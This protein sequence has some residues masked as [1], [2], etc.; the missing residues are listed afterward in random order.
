MF[1]GQCGTNM[2]DDSVF[3]PECG[4]PVTPNPA[5]APT[6]IPTPINPDPV[7]NSATSKRNRYIGLGVV[8]AAVVLVVVLCV[9]LFG[10]RSY[11]SVV[12]KGMNAL[13]DADGKA[14]INL[15]P[16]DFIDYMCDEEDVTK[17]ELI[18]ELEEELDDE[19]EG[20]SAF[21]D[22]LDIDY[23]ITKTKDF[24][25]KNLR[26]LSDECED[27]YGFEVKDAKEATI[28]FT[29]KGSTLGDIMPTMKWTV[30]KVGRN[31]C[32]WEPDF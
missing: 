26:E 20:L 30:I 27:E 14:M 21:Y 11:N 2:P 6:P 22:V 17:A 28:Q 3:C 10:G 31:W 1:C 23:E 25:K 24:S 15:F 32:L 13:L 18:D 16:K 19:L 8:A 29:I 7:N 12:K 9:T 5:P 4:A